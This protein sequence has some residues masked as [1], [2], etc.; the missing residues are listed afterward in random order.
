MDICDTIFTAFSLLTG[1]VTDLTA[2]YTR[3]ISKSTESFGDIVA[4][5][6]IQG[7]SALIRQFQVTWFCPEFG[8]LQKKY[9]N[10]NVREIEIPA[11]KRK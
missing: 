5:W 3:N 2:R 6:K 11:L 4:T 1:N 8:P 9:V 7:S 10:G